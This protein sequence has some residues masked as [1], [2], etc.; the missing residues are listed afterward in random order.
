MLIHNYIKLC[1]TNDPS[2]IFV[3]PPPITNIESLSQSTISSLDSGSFGR[4][5]YDVNIKQQT[6]SE[7]ADTDTMMAYYEKLDLPPPQ[8]ISNVFVAADLLSHSSSYSDQYKC[9]WFKA[10]VICSSIISAG[11]C[12]DSRIISLSIAPNYKEI[13]SIMAVTG[14]IF[15]KQ[16]SNAITWYEQKKKY[17]P[18]Q[19]Q[20][21]IN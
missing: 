6:T 21:V 5:W 9:A 15:P 7:V 12:P 1:N 11:E 20:S 18:M 16:Y 4:N 8:D 10:K 2:S 17:C 14:A 19:H 13:A 3:S